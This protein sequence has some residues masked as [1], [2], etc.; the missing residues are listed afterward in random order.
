MAASL[1]GIREIFLYLVRVGAGTVQPSE[2]VLPES[3][4]WEKLKALARYHSLL[5]IVLDGYNAL[6][7]RDLL[8]EGQKMDPAFERKWI[9]S[10]LSSYEKRYRNYGEVVAGLNAFYA[11]HGLRMLLLKGYG[12]S[13]NWPVPRH[14][15]CGDID[16]WMFGRWKEADAL[17]MAE[18]GIKA[19]HRHQHHTTFRYEGQFVENHFDFVDVYSHPSSRRFEKILKGLAPVG[20]GNVRIGN[21]DVLTPSPDFNALF[22]L[23][24]AASHFAS[25]RMTVRQVLDWAFFVRE[26]GSEVNWD[27][28]LRTV[29]DF[30]MDTFLNCLDAICAEDFAFGADIFP[31]F[32]A[33]PALKAR[34]L[35]DLIYP[36][37]SEKE[38]KAILR[39]FA[40][41]FRRWRKNAWKNR[42]VYPESPFVSFC[43][44]LWSHMRKPKILRKKD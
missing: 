30:R 20:L 17:L 2:N 21:Q 43:Y 19:G 35:N 36:E 38:P 5:A 16:I 7:A 1:H 11:S 33:D 3:I 41:R 28:V 4:P 31:P 6:C 40:F 22:L 29:S 12:L 8:D 13:R 14:R 44:L 15:P 10:T 9:S 34:M 37:F 42:M 32:E 25:E 23:R 27:F 18:K 24:H 39:R 26:C